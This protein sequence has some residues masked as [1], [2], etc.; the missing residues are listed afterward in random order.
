MLIKLGLDTT[1][2]EPLRLMLEYYQRLVEFSL[3]WAEPSLK[4]VLRHVGDWIGLDLRLHAHWKYFFVLMWLYFGS[5]A[6]IA[7]RRGWRSSAIE[8]A[9]WGGLVATTASVA[10]GAIALDDPSMFPV[11][12]PIAGF[13]VYEIVQGAWTAT[14]HNFEGNTWGQT[15]RYYFIRFAV[16]N[17]VIGGMAVLFGQQAKKFGFSNPNLLLFIVFVI[18]LAMRNVG[19]GM[20]LAVRDREDGESWVSR[21]RR[22]ASARLGVLLFI[23]ISGTALFLAL[24]AGLQLAGL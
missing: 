10:S 13:V 15:F 4:S 19:V 18:M 14:F 21:F 12:I 2:T 8:Y 16:A 17:A 20:W 5:D 1:F 9:L 6:K 22:S 24:N 7:W 11:V 3:D 23:T